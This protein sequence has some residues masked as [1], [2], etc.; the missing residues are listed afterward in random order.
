MKVITNIF[1]AAMF[2]VFGAHVLDAQEEHF[3]VEFGYEDGSLIFESSGPG[4]DAAGIFEA[5][6][7][8]LNMDGSQVAE[9]PGFASNFMEGDETFS[10]TSG[11]SMFLNANQSSTLGSYLTYFNPASNQFE[12]TDATITIEDNS[13]G[14]T[15]DLIV[16]E[17]DLS[18]DMSQYVVTSDGFEIDTHV[19]YILSSGAQEGLYGILLNLE[20]DNLSG[21]LSVATSDQFWVVFNNGLSEEVFEGAIGNFSAVPEPSSSVIIVAVA[22]GILRRKRS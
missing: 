9:D 21:D 6:F 17:S 13:P 18:G 12:S 3:D 15:S 14:A 20:S 10:I 5:E 16:T 4:I 8:V 7:E 1:L 11:D 22:L 2:C 19:D